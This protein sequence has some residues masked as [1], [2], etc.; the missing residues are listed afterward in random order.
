ME[1][2]TMGKVI[3]SARIFNIA[4]EVRAES[5]VI[6]LQGIRTVEVDDAL[7]DTGATFLSL[8]ARL[9][10]Q[11]G[12]KK[13]GTRTAKTPAGLVTFARCEPVRLVVQERDCITQVYEVPDTCPV[14]I[15][16]I[17][18][19]SLDFVVD[20]VGQRLIGNP[21]HG[22]EQM[23]DMFFETMDAMANDPEIRRELEAI[24]LEFQ[25]TDA[26]GLELAP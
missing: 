26:D 6:P 20:P 23:I 24:E 7:I 11:L 3:V 10:N 25:A 1:I 21:D 19:E 2:A 16:Q 9:I 18:L 15:G 22:G 17:P 4:D 13:V 14:L 12:L 8:P 5:G